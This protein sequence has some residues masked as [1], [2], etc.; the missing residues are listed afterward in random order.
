MKGTCS[1]ELLLS[2]C[3]LP[4]RD[5]QGLGMSPSPLPVVVAAQ[6]TGSGIRVGAEA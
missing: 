1:K 2:A 3:D 4:Q 6:V 5:E